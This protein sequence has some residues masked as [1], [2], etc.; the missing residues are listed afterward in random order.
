MDSIT[1]HDMFQSLT[2]LGAT[3]E[4][5]ARAKAHLEFCRYKIKHHHAMAYLEAAGS[6]VADRQANAECHEDY[7]QAIRDFRG[8]T[9]DYE[10]LRS[11]RKHAE[12]TIDLFRTLESSRRAGHV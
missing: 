5:Y 4:D 10:H 12:L 7:R 6:T 2:Y 11:K 8:A 3:D 9:Y 1:E